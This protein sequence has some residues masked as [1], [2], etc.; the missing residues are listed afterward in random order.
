MI[1]TLLYLLIRFVYSIAVMIITLHLSSH[2][3]DDWTKE[4]EE[5]KEVKKGNVAAA[6]YFGSAILGIAFFIISALQKLYLYPGQSVMSIVISMLI[7][8]G[9]V[10][11]AAIFGVFTAYVTIKTLDSLTE[12]I[13]EWKELKKGNI[14]IAIM[15]SVIILTVTFIASSVVDDLIDALF[16]DLLVKA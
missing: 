10:A 5:W 16:L 2:L 11:I 12:N 8:L 1:M 9:A 13:D 4:I 14:A 6:I 15:M 3:F 7:D